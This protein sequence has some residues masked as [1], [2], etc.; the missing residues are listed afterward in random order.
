MNRRVNMEK[1]FTLSD[2][3]LRSIRTIHNRLTFFE[4]ELVFKENDKHRP[5]ADDSNLSKIIRVHFYLRVNTGKMF[6]QDFIK[7]REKHFSLP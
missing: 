6:I 1:F 3:G 7:G 2:L 5:T 4:M